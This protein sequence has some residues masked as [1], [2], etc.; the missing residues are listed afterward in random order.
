MHSTIYKVQGM[1]LYSKYVNDGRTNSATRNRSLGPS[2]P[3]PDED[4]KTSS[5]TNIDRI[6]SANKFSTCHTVTIKDAFNLFKLPL[7]DTN[8]ERYLCQV[9]ERWPS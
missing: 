5:K 8:V 6:R 4:T 3:I 7:L 9:F 1:V 2:L